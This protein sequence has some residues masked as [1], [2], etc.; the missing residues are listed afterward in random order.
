M[1]RKDSIKDSARGSIKDSDKK[2]SVSVEKAFA[3]YVSQNILGMLGISAYVLA[4]TFFISMA[5]GADGITA[6]N[7]VLPLYSLIFA[8]GSMMGT[9]SATKFT[10]SRAR[11]EQEPDFYFSNAIIFALLF[12]ILFMAAGVFFPGEIMGLMGAD[13]R[14][15]EVGTTYTRI[16]MTFAPF[17]MWNYIF[18]AFVRNDG[19]PS[20]AMTA[21]LSSSLFNI[22]MDYVL[23]FPLK[24]GMAG[25]ALAT[26]VSPIVGVTICSIHIFSRK[27]KV[28]LRPVKPSITRL[29]QSCQLGVAGFIGE[30]SSGITT[31]VFNFLI[32]GI[33]GNVGVAAYGIVANIAIVATAIFNGVAQGAQPLISNFHGRKDEASA[34]KAFLLSVG[35]ALVLACLLLFLVNLFAKPL[36][37]VFNSE[38]NPEMAAYAVDG[39]RLYFIGF[40]F[41][42]INIVGIGY[43][44]ATEAV[45]WA[46]AASILRGMAAITVCAFTLASLFGMT[47]VW[48][49]FPAAELV[50]MAVTLIGVNRKRM[51]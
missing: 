37:A 7:I 34:R 50:T 23:M 14:I 49:A 3:R 10:L 15:I 51:H 9:G 25:A 29:F 17:F 4:D 5:E 35:T 16:F 38:Q 8:I 28:H 43:L 24:L 44:S 2:I 32:L 12:G 47:G 19:A 11:N 26:A 48:L 33:A 46:F 27:S 18:N 31:M 40:F 36:T 20:I 45:G 30:I 13:V 42:A 39:I 6:L 21:T 22:I 1:N 41:A